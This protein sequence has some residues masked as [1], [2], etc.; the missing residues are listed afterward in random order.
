MD[1][2]TLTLTGL[3]AIGVVNV[4]SFFKPDMDSRVKFVLSA[5]VAFAVTFIPQEL[6]MVILDKAKEAITVA[7]AASGVYKLAMKAGGE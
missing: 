6:G 2:A 3:A 7:L 4:V 5:V 1:L